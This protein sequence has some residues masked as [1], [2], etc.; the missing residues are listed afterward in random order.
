MNAYLAFQLTGDFEKDIKQ[1]FINFERQE[2][3]Q[4]T[5]EVLEE[6]D[7]LKKL[8]GSVEEGSEIACLAHDLGRVVKHEDILEFCMM[9]QIEVTDE[10]RLLPSILHQ[11]LSGHIA[12]RVFGISNPSILDGIKYHTTSRA[13]P[14]ELEKEVFLADKMSWKEAG[15][16]EIAQE[17]KCAV[18]VSKD[19]G[20][21]LYLEDMH[22][23]RD[24]LKVYHR[25]S[26]EA[27][28]YFTGGHHDHL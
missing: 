17:I 10:E 11:K 9:N 26:R 14:T 27:Y 3:Y 15:Y 13:N 20:M 28:V 16:R 23:K 6:L 7:Y 12:E 24:Q 2:T 22:Q 5:I 21:R 25:D 1:Y 8:Y 4:H 19:S 18:K